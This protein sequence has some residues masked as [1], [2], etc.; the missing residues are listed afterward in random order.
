L[1]VEA[2]GR[3]TEELI[4][5]YLLEPRSGEIFIA[6]GEALGIWFAK[7]PS[8]E[9]AQERHVSRDDSLHRV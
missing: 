7:M 1:A 6:Y 4:G 3:S 5:D 2:W 8:A 9:G